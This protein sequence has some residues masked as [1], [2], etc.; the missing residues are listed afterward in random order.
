MFNQYSDETLLS[1]RSSLLDGLEKVG[2]RLADGTFHVVGQ[3]GAAP[4]SQSGQLTLALL[5]EVNAVLVN[6]GFP[7]VFVG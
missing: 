3:K 4:P 2:Q 6:R 1:T 7:T 5:V